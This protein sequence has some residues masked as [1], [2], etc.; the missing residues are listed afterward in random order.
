MAVYNIASFGPQQTLFAWLARSPNLEGTLQCH[1]WQ[2]TQLSH[3]RLS[4]NVHVRALI[5]RWFVRWGLYHHVVIR[6][7]L[8]V[9]IARLPFLRKEYGI[10]IV[11]VILVSC[12]A[13]SVRKSLNH[14]PVP[15]KIKFLTRRSLATASSM[16]ILFI[17]VSLLS[18]NVFTPDLQDRIH[19]RI[20]SLSF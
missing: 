11:L 1:L 8:V 6:R 15:I 5:S 10:S 9:L 19:S 13:F 2:V 17:A 7:C 16:H 12:Q 18:V 20:S 3:S 4:P 14:V